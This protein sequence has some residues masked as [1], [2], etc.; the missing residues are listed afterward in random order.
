MEA[1]SRDG[2]LVSKRLEAFATYAQQARC[3]RVTPG[4][5]SALAFFFTGHGPSGIGEK[6]FE[7]LLHLFGQETPPEM[8]LGLA[9]IYSFLID[10]TDCICSL[11]IAL[12]DLFVAYALMAFVRYSFL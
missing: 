11:L 4:S 9:Y 6:T 10:C 7:F 5:L 8:L 2:D 1:T 3:S 12:L